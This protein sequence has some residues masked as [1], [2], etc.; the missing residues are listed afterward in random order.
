[1]EGS[2]SHFSKPVVYATALAVVLLAVAGAYR[3][4]ASSDPV[5]FGVNREGVEVKVGEAKEQLTNAARQLGDLQTKLDAQ[6]R[7]LRKSESDLQAKDAQVRSLLSELQAT[8]QRA[9]ASPALRAAAPQIDALARRS[10]QLPDAQQ[11]ASEA[12]A[13]EKLRADILSA[14]RDI[15]TAH[16]IIQSIGR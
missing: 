9:D 3:I 14:G 15:E 1:M 2:A 12:A 4:V 5:S 8:S 11:A 10:P 7:A 6:E 13:R 16:N